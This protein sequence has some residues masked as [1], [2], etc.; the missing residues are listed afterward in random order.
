MD[1]LV[2]DDAS[3]DGTGALADG[4]AAADGRISVLHRAGKEGLGRAYLAGFR[5]VLA[6]RR[7]YS[8]VIQMDADFSH[9]PARLGALLAACAD[10]GADVAVGSRYVEGGA[11]V[12]W[13]ARRR[14]LSRAG[15]LYA[16][17]ILG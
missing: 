15:G 13:S 7:A 17:L 4:L 9:D 3:P 16:R 11:T 6:D 10:G 14:L 8:H 1:V 2:I 12:G 5:E